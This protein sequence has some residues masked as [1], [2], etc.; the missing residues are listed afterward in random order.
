MGFHGDPTE[1]PPGSIR[2]RN[3]PHEGV[4]REKGF[5]P[6]TLTLAR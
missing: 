6:S 2:I 3:G 4:E 5:E 1:T